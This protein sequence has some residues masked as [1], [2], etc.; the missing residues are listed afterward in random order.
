VKHLSAAALLIAIV[1][2]NAWASH[3]EFHFHRFPHAAAG[4]AAP[5]GLPQ[6]PSVTL[7]RGTAAQPWHQGWHGGFRHDGDHEHFQGP[8]WH[9]G[10]GV[11]FLGSALLLPGYAPA[12]D[13][14]AYRFPPAP[15]IAESPPVYVERSDT[16]MPAPAPEQRWYYCAAADAYYPYLKECP[17][18]WT[19]VVTPSQ[20]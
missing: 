4:I 17:E 19:V 14:P 8:H 18:G 9:G 10:A 15:T 12:F 2:G 16:A 13:D 20:P 11:I 6:T 5:G 1:A 7:P 3:G